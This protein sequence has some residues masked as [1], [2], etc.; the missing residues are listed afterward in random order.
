M[1]LPEEDMESRTYT[2]HKLR[3][4]LAISLN[5]LMGDHNDIFKD[6]R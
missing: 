1:V 3:K 4:D 2:G 5:S 6:L